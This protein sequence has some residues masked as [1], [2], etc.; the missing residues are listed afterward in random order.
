[1]VFAIYSSSSTFCINFDIREVQG[2]ELLW[3]KE[4]ELAVR[5]NSRRA[6]IVLNSDVVFMFVVRVITSGF[7]MSV[8]RELCHEIQLIA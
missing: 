6:A 3:L 8:E 5:S 4:L 7:L 1:V 2:V